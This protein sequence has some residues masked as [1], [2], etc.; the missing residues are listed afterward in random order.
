MVLFSFIAAIAL[1]VQT[2]GPAQMKNP[3][4][5]PITDSCGWVV[6]SNPDLK[7]VA[8]ICEA[9]RATNLPNF[10]CNV[11]I[12]RKQPPFLN[13]LFF[14]SDVVTGEVTYRE[15]KEEL[16]DLRVKG[17]PATPDELFANR[18]W[19]EG[20]FAPPGKSALEGV[21]NPVFRFQHASEE[22]GRSLLVF[23]YAV[24]KSGNFSWTLS[25]GFG[26]Y[27]PAFSGKMF[28]DKTTGLLMRFTREAS[29]IGSATPFRSVSEEINYDRVKIE[30]LGEFVLPVRAKFVSC[31][32]DASACSENVV[33]YHA[34][35][36]FAATTKITSY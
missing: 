17:K 34:C 26:V 11:R 27:Q 13:A 8:R 15:G 14:Q 36:K 21:S 4:D 3:A 18:Q 29:G 2:T 30:G 16:S 12:A 22:E 19:T 31:Q 24:P 5:L 33:E 1:L 28:I 10:I 7:P 23:D 25:F 6:G 20:Q 9:D 32:K 35:R